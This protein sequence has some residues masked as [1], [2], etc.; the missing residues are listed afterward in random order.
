MQLVKTKGFE[1]IVSKKSAGLY[2]MFFFYG[3]TNGVKQ[4]LG[5]MITLIWK[6]NNICGYL[7]F[8]IDMLCSIL[9]LL[10]F[11]KIYNSEKNTANKYYLSVISIWGVIV[12]LL[13][14]VMSGIRI[15]A[16]VFFDVVPLQLLPTLSE[17]EMMINILMI[18]V[19]I[20]IVGFTSDKRWMTTIAIF[21]LF[22]FLITDT[23][24]IG[25]GIL[26]IID[27]DGI[28]YLVVMV[29]GYICLGLLFREKRI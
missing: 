1:D 6:A 9:I 4:I 7:N 2:R 22:T 17:Y 10:Y 13:P 18:C 11:I 29:F 23:F 25:R 8:G 27:A 12:S 3:L 5:A 14:F 15:A 20:I 26:N 16:T 24:Q 28:Y 21:I 19:A